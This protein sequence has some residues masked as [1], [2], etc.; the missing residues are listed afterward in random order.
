MGVSVA[1][2]M[3]KKEDILDTSTFNDIAVG[4]Q[5]GNRFFEIE[6]P[7]TTIKFTQIA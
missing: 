1:F 3:K 4:F 7:N 6:G 2:G 5:S